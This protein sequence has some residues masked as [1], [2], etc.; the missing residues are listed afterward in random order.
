M[1]KIVILGASGFI[2]N[3]LAQTLA[4]SGL[5]VNIVGVDIKPSKFTSPKYFHM[6]ADIRDEKTLEWCLG[7]SRPDIIIHAAA[8]VGVYKIKRNPEACVENNLEVTRTLMKVIDKLNLDK[9]LL[10]FFSSSEVYGNTLA[11]NADENTYE[12]FPEGKRGSYAITKLLE[13]NLLQNFYNSRK[14]ENSQLA[15]IRL[16]NIV[17]KWQ[18]ED[19]IIPK[20]FRQLNNEYYV[21]ANQTARTF[22]HID[23]L[24]YSIK[25]LIEYYTKG[26]SNDFPR[27]CN[28]GSQ[29][30]R[31]FI[32]MNALAHEINKWLERYS[33][34]TGYVSSS[35]VSSSDIIIRKPGKT[36][37]PDKYLAKD[38]DDDIY[39]IIDRVGSSME[40]LKKKETIND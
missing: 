39:L 8:D 11:A 34:K 9:H 16:F 3:H 36:N 26:E 25:T 33:Y 12:L 35:R 17:G 38:Y 13:E 21:S 40:N 32:T 37:I 29:E 23:F 2:G 27:V 18:S 10:V 28:F 5:D 7:A 24:K 31:N 1:R 19:F 22:C 6:E 20:M 4:F 15:I 14:R 30:D